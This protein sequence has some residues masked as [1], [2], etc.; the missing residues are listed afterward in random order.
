MTSPASQPG[1]PP[2]A[3]HGERATAES[4]GTDAERY[5]RARPPYPHALVAGVVGVPPEGPARDVLDVGCGTG[6]AAR[7]LQAAGC[8]VLGVEPDARMAA[9][10]RERGLPVEVATFEDWDPAGRTFDAV[11]AA[12]SWHWVDPA[13][14]AA[15]AAAVLRPGG[16]LAVFGHVFEP[17]DDVARAF[18][19]AFRRA[20]PDS[21][22]ATASGRRPV[23][24]YQAGYA[25]VAETF[26][27]TGLFEAPEQW[28]F[29]VE[30]TYTRDAWLDLLPT[31]G[32]LT[33][34]GP[35]ARAEVLA[36]VGAA[37]D[38][39][40]GSFTIPFTTLATVAVRSRG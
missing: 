18:A 37:I 19:E 29:D 33:R 39:L 5:D 2:A 6:I 25:A 8:A 36:A 20:V 11:V 21:P 10:A 30:R 31:T 26:R 38:A 9:Y 32:G 4:F 27:G 14:G 15:Q 23:E 13:A 16:R 17:P 40:G 35:D 22:F 12:Q 28:R 3:L 34:V 1:R 24:T 7:Q